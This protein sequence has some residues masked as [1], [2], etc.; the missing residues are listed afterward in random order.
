MM[1]EEDIVRNIKS[2][3]WPPDA[4]WTGVSSAT[5][6]LPVSNSSI[7]LLP[8]LLWYLKHQKRC[9]GY[10]ILAWSVLQQSK[11]RCRHKFANKGFNVECFNSEGIINR[12]KERLILTFSSRLHRS[13]VLWSVIAHQKQNYT[14]VRKWQT[15]KAKREG[16]T[17]TNHE[18]L[19]VIELLVDIR[20]V[21]FLLILEYTVKFFD[22][23][24]R[25]TS[26]F[27]FS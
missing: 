3:W 4:I 26:A 22:Q 16:K 14:R 23:A 18:L 20:S 2:Y 11:Q 7:L 17:S 8:R 13:W 6:S 25:D 12:K 21:L 1:F 24:A 5:W 10:N 27:Y 19:L 9:S 15:T